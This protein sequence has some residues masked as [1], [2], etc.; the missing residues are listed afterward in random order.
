MSVHLNGYILVPQDRLNDI[1]AALV[2][3]IR[4]TR[5]EPGCISFNVD[6]NPDI[7]GRFDVAEEFT[8]ADSFAAHQT[9]V[10]ASDWGRISAGIERDYTITGLD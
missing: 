1:R 8:D 9:R 3:H 2:D 6:E 7:P 5:Q 4:L 10:K